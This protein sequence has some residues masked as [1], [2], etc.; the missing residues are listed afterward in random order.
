MFNSELAMVWSLFFMAPFFIFILSRL[1][2]FS[3]VYAVKTPEVHHVYEPEI[4]ISYDPPMSR[5]EQW[6]AIVNSTV[7][8]AMEGDKSARDWVTKNVFQ[9]P[10]SPQNPSS[11]LIREAVDALKTVGYKAGNVKKVA[12]ELCATNNYTVLED[13]IQ[14]IIKNC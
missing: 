1:G 3:S 4:T 5:Q 11:A 7:Q 12:N 9:E 8:S 14:D 6:E 13:L 10:V 2:L